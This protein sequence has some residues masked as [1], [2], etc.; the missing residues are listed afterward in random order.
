MISPVNTVLWI[1]LT[2]CVG[3]KVTD[4]FVSQSVT[5]AAESASQPAWLK[6]LKM[7]PPPLRSKVRDFVVTEG[8]QHTRTDVQAH[9]HRDANGE[10]LNYLECNASQF[11]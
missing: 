3:K 1:P 4:I 9:A 5:R 2:P 11:Y 6:G 7:G 10:V 8:E